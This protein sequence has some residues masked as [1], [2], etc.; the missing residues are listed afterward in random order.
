[1]NQYKVQALISGFAKDWKSSISAM[2]ADVMR[3]FTN[4]K[5]GTIII[6]E[7]LTQFVSYYERFLALLKQPGFKSK[8]WTDLVGPH[9]IMVEIKKHRTNFS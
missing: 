8:N 5:N 3:A 9:S 6:Q 4:F 1:V 7:I 2:D